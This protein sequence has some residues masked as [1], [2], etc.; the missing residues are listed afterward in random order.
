MGPVKR[1]LAAALLTVLFGVLVAGG[2]W[3]VVWVCEKYPIFISLA[4]VSLAAIA[5]VIVMF[6]QILALLPKDTGRE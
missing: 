3:M 1:Y 4:V 5:M 6:C 2:T